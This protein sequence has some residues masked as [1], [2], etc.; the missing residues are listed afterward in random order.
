MLRRQNPESVFVNVSGA[1]KSIAPAYLAWGAGTTNRVILL[2]RQATQAPGLLK[3][4]QIR[5]MVLVLGMSTVKE[6]AISL[7]L[8]FSSFLE[9]S[10]N[11]Y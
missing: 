4:L 2:G 6:E 5:A 8:R 10:E 7:K 9:N 1:Q 3:R 11:Q